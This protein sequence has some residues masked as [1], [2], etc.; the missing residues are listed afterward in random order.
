MVT[1]R[2]NP[3]PFQWPIIVASVVIG[4]TLLVATRA[5]K[6]TLLRLMPPWV[7]LVLGLG[8]AVGGVITLA[9]MSSQTLTGLD[10]ERVGL[11]LLLLLWVLYGT[12]AWAYVGPAALLQE[13]LLSAFAGSCGWRAWQ[14]TKQVRA[15]RALVLAAVLDSGVEEG[16]P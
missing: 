7:L 4:V 1:V 12:L 8:M 5:T 13:E 15:T 14:V 2:T 10:V 9:G 3:G 6:S 11:S 16:Q